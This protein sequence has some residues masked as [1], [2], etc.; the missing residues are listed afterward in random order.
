MA[1]APGCLE[2][3]PTGNGVYVKYFSGEIKTGMRFAFQ[4]AG[5]DVGQRYAACG[6]EFFPEAAFARQGIGVAGEGGDEPVQAFGAQFGPAEVASEPGFGQKV[7][8]KAA[9]KPLRRR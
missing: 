2:V 4:G 6:H 7:L 1:G 8:P 5:V 3:E 9:G